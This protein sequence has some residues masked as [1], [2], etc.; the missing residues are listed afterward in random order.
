MTVSIPAENMLASGDYLATVRDFALS[1]GI[2]TNIL[3]HGTDISLENLI[4]PPVL[5]NNLIFSRVGVNLYNQLKSPI[6]D[7]VEFGLSMTAASHGSLGV[8]V[9][10]APD[11]ESALQVLA[12]YF[13]TR[14]NS[15]D[16]K[17]Q[18]QEQQTTVCLVDKFGAHATEKAVQ[19]FFD[20]ATLISIATNIQRALSSHALQGE[21]LIYVN[22]AEPADFPHHLLTGRL[23]LLFDQKTLEL[24]IPKAWMK[25]PLNISSPELA[26]AALEK[27]EDEMK[28]ISP[29]D[30]VSKIKKRIRN[31]GALIPKID[32][33]A[34]ELN[35]SEAT[36]KR[37]L[38]E[39]NTHYQQLK[40]THRLELAKAMILDGKT[41]LETISSNLGF[42]DASNFTKAFKNWTG[43]SPKQFREQHSAPTVGTKADR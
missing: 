26:K 24:H 33:I 9:Q 20:F 40:N 27:C 19:H 36:L 35:M 34:K 29:L 15:Q 1:K 4:N 43:L 39:Q 12:E 8:A 5:V 31:A 23:K 3:L 22:K 10:C 38:S 16:I 42:S 13:N 2:S 18:T 11:L 14:I 25:T 6:A 32:E 28:N 41:S 30:L 37:R 7:A 21:I 17:F